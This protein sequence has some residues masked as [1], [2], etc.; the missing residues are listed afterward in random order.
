MKIVERRL[1]RTSKG[2][3]RKAATRVVISAQGKRVKA[4][5]IDADSST[6]SEELLESFARNVSRARRENKALLGHRDGAYY[7]EDCLGGFQGIDIT[8]YHR[9][10]SDKKNDLQYQKL[11]LIMDTPQGLTGAIK[12]LCERRRMLR[13]AGDGSG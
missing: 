6:F 7:F 3:K 11:L 10:F 1:S 4:M 9:I 2:S 5:Q 13:R 8:H 12:F